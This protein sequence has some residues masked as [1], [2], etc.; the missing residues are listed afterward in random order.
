[1]PTGVR[2]YLAA[3]GEILRFGRPTASVHAL[4]G[5][6]GFFSVLLVTLGVVD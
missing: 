5:A 3:A 6:V 4:V 1:V 2:A